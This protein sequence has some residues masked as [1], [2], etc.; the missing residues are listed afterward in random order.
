MRKC[1]PGERSACAPCPAGPRS[2]PSRRRRVAAASAPQT[3]WAGQGSLSP[4]PFVTSR[5]AHAVR[6]AA[7][8]SGAAALSASA[9]GSAPPILSIRNTATSAC[10]LCAAT[11]AASQAAPRRRALAERRRFRSACHVWRS[12]MRL[13]CLP[14]RAQATKTGGESACQ[15]LQLSAPAGQA[16]GATTSTSLSRN[17]QRR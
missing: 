2:R 11:Q 15:T 1:K 9:T 4:K 7:A 10:V 8:A 5:C 13:C 14:A 17:P 12:T 16:L 3:C 6:P